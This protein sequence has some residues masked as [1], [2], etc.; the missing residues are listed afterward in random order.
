MNCSG[1]AGQWDFCELFQRLRDEI[2]ALTQKHSVATTVVSE[3]EVLDLPLNG[4][5]FT[6]L[7]LLQ[8]GVVPLTP[9]LAEAG[10][11]LRASPPP[12]QPPAA[13]FKRLYRTR[14][15]HLAQLHAFVKTRLR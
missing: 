10:G 1:K 6:Q 2:T 9:G 11:S 13:T 3:Q 8:P 4:R 15:E 7:G 5:N 12:P 14:A